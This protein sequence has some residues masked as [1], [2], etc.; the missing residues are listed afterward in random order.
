MKANQKVHR[1]KGRMI[2]TNSA[3]SEKR[4]RETTRTK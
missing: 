3:E 2:E 1:K 4:G